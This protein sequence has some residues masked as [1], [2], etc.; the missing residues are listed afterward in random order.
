[1]SYGKSLTKFQCIL[2]KD[3]EVIS[4]LSYKA[5]LF[6]IKFVS[7]S[8][9]RA[10]LF[11]TFSPSHRTQITAS[12]VSILMKRLDT[13]ETISPDKIPVVIHKNISPELSRI[14]ANA[15]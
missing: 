9:T 8:V 15:A 12:E 7:N 4:S 14:L 3:P 11:L 13:K 2:I 1:M 6:A 5:K 10:I